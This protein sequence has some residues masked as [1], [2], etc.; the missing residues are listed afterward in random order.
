MAGWILFSEKG[1]S[2]IRRGRALVCRILVY[3]LV[4]FK[5]THASSTFVG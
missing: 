1:L 5:H 4:A 3:K 2:E